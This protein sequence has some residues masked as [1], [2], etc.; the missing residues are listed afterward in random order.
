M[1]QN[2]H[3]GPNFAK[4]GTEVVSWGSPNIQKTTK[5]LQPPILLKIV[6]DNEFRS[7]PQRLEKL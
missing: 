5:C 6:D 3:H 1:F 4:M 7:S 2:N